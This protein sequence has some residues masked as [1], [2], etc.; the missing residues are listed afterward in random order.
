MKRPT[1]DESSDS[2]DTDF[3]RSKLMVQIGEAACRECWRICVVTKDGTIPT[4]K[5][6]GR[7]VRCSGSGEVAC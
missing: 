2:D 7:T 6:L 1:S 4:H 5:R 3:G